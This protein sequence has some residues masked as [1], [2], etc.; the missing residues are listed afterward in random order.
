[1]SSLFSFCFFF[2]YCINKYFTSH[3][4]YSKDNK[5]QNKLSLLPRSGVTGRIDGFFGGGEGGERGFRSR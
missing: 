5:Q 4:Y 3:H 2:N 1:M